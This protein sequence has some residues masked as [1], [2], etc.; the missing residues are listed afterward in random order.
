MMIMELSWWW[1]LYSIELSTWQSCLILMKLQVPC[2]CFMEMLLPD[3]LFPTKSV[4]HNA[5]WGVENVV[6]WQKLHLGSEVLGLHISSRH[7]VVGWPVP[8]L[9]ALPSQSNPRKL[10][11]LSG[12]NFYDRCTHHSITTARIEEQ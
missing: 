12:T 9:L 4:L 2:N 7:N 10:C 1:N 3:F 11:E 5:N 8:F 6:P